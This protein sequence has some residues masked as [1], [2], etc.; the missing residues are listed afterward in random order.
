MPP[1]PGPSRG[2]T[3]DAWLRSMILELAVLC[4]LPGR[5]AGFEP[6]ALCGAAGAPA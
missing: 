1:V 3:S 6:A 2:P 5:P 4:I